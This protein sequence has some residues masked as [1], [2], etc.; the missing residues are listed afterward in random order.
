MMIGGG[1]VS[2]A[3][4]IKVTTFLILGVIALSEIRGERDVHVFR[5]RLTSDVQRQAL[6]VALLGLLILFVAILLMRELSDA[7]LRGLVF[8]TISA[9]ANVGLSMGL[10]ADLPPPAQALLIVLMFV[11]RVGTVTVA[12]ALALRERKSGFRYPEERPVVG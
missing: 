5:R 10:T 9:F 3:G 6:T 2:M 11:G 12:T 1:S 8:E 4:G 7:P